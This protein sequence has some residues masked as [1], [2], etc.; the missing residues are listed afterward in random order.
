MFLCLGNSIFGN[1]FAL[2]DE[3]QRGIATPVSSPVAPI[4]TY[5]RRMPRKLDFSS[6]YPEETKEQPA[7]N[8]MTKMLSKMFQPQCEWSADIYRVLPI[9]HRCFLQLWD[10]YNNMALFEFGNRTFPISIL[11]CLESEYGW[12]NSHIE[13]VEYFRFTISYVLFKYAEMSGVTTDAS[14][15]VVFKTTYIFLRDFFFPFVI[16]TQ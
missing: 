11:Y 5:K 7:N 6:L 16:Q 4:E 14:K 15:L 13:P 1:F 10:K 2:D 9:A 3:L 8:N 12:G